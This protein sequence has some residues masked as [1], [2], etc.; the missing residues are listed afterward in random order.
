MLPDSFAAEDLVQETYLKLW[1]K[2]HELKE[3]EH[4]EAYAVIT[5]R[6]LCMNHLRDNKDKMAVSYDHTIPEPKSLTNELE[7]ADEATLIKQLIDKLPEQQR[8]IITLR[9]C[10]GYSYDEIKEITGLDT[11]HIR[12]IVSRVRKIL[13]SQFDKIDNYEYK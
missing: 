6:N 8:Q 1:N 4:P 2:R 10:E 3:V 9:H 5:L 13:R 11:V 7:V 12:V